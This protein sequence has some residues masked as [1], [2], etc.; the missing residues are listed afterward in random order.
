MN[1]NITERKTDHFKAIPSVLVELGICTWTKE[2]REEG[3]A[4]VMHEKLIAAFRKYTI[5]IDLTRPRGVF[6]NES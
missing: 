3:L 1:N 5:Q 6:E 2:K 4:Y